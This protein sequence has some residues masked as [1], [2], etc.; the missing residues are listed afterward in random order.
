MFLILPESGICRV[1][2]HECL[3]VFLEAGRVVDDGFLQGIDPLFLQI[4]HHL[5]GTDR[6]VHAQR[7]LA[8]SLGKK[9]VPD[10]DGKDV[11]LEGIV[12]QVPRSLKLV[13]QG[14]GLVE[15]PPL[16]LDFNDRHGRLDGDVVLDPAGDHRPER[17]NR[18]VGLT[19]RCEHR[20]LREP[21]P[22]GKVTGALGGFF[23][24]LFSLGLATRL[25]LDLRDGDECLGLVLAL[26]K[27]LEASPVI[28]LG[29][30]QIL[31]I[32]IGGGEGEENGL[33]GLS[34]GPLT[35]DSLE[36]LCSPRIVSRLERRSTFPEEVFG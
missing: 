11:E 28:L 7:F 30:F 13:K 15:V 33:Q 2:I 5:F 19:L 17:R 9:A 6:G 32:E 29:L 12:H 14:K 24:C 22:G 21:C 10:P 25:G 27:L 8:L 4:H 34:R 26:G 35:E 18:L 20:G 23:Q 36:T 31:L 16:G 1:H 3:G